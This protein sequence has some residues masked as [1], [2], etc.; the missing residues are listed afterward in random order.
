[1]ILNLE[2]HDAREVHSEN[3]KSITKRFWNLRLANNKVSFYK[4][5]RTTSRGQGKIKEQKKTDVDCDAFMVFF[6]GEPPKT[7][8]FWYHPAVTGPRRC[9]RFPTKSPPPPHSRGAPSSEY[10]T[11]DTNRK[12]KVLFESYK[13]AVFCTNF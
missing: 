13:S 4:Q 8:F 1:M 7:V 6:R 3:G 12:E 5:L 10:R 2:L 9:S 11:Q